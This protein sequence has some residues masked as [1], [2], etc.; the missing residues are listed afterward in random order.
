MRGERRPRNGIFTCLAPVYDIAAGSIGLKAV[1]DALEL[2]G[3]ERVLDL[4]GGTGR[5]ASRL[6]ARGCQPIVVDLSPAMARR[7]QRKGLATL[8]GNALALPL[9]DRSVD[10][11]AVLDA[12]HHMPRLSQVAREICRVLKPDGCAV[13]LEPDPKTLLGRIV[14]RAESM[15]GMQSLIL[16][17]AAL[18]QVFFEAGMIASVSRGRFHQCLVARPA[19]DSTLR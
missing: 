4:A 7:A 12:F 2:R 19:G 6:E 16:E 10:R 17:S 18:A 3:G 13:I 9:P 8:L 1:I 15:L 11:V 5:L 14:A